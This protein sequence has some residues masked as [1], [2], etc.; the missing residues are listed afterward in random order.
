MNKDG[1][2]LYLT[3]IHQNHLEDPARIVLKRRIKAMLK[4]LLFTDSI[5]RCCTLLEN[6]EGDRLPVSMEDFPKELF[7]I[8]MNRDLLFLNLFS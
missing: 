6:K 2:H 4:I 7:P 8:L 3:I 5:I 1:R